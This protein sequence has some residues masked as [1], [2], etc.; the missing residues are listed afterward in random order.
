VFQGKEGN[1]ASQKRK[2]PHKEK[3]NS[4]PHEGRADGPPLST[5]ATP[6]TETPSSSTITVGTISLTSGLG[7]ASGDG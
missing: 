5:L 4:H 2:K 3:K 7:A 1:A 6:S